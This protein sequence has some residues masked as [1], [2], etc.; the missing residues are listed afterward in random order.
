MKRRLFCDGCLFDGLFD[1]WIQLSTFEACFFFTDHLQDVY[2]STQT[3]RP[4]ERT[5]QMLSEMIGNIYIP[6]LVICL[7]LKIV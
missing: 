7:E 4:M 5:S 1:L 2:I 3:D 6:S